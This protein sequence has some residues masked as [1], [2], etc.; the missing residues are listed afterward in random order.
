MM[1]FIVH[2]RSEQEVVTHLAR[3][4]SFPKGGWLALHKEGPRRIAPALSLCDP[5]GH[6]RMDTP[7]CAAMSDARPE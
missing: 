5:Y 3:P 7:V 6:T 2:W 4:S 1:R